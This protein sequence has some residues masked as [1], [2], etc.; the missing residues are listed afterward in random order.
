MSFVLANATC[1]VNGYDFTTDLNQVT[2]SASADELDSTTFG[3]SGWRSRAGG[4]KSVTAQLAGYWQS[5]ESDAPDPQAFP[6]LGV[7][8]RVVTIAPDN[9][10]GTVAYLFQAVKLS[11]QLFGQVGEMTPFSLDMSGSGVGLVRGRVAAA[12][13]EVS[14]TGPVGSPV[15]LPAVGASQHLYV[16]L[17]VFQ[18]GTTLTL[19]VESSPD[20]TFAAPSTVATIG[21]I[22][23]AGGVWVTP[24]PGP[25]ADTWYR[26]VATD[27]TGTCRVAAAIGVGT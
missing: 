9:A 20:D 11:Y 17:H 10:E 6:D 21:P 12:H 25:I 24:T 1:W 14:A 19:A 26:L 13:Q 2:L 4:L 22:A 18:A 27:V 3:S 8:D 7:A 5:A 15:Q 23:V 16:A